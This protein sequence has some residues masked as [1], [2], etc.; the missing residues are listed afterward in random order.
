[1]EERHCKRAILTGRC[2]ISLGVTVV[3]AVALCFVVFIAILFIY[4]VVRKTNKNERASTAGETASA[5]AYA[6]TPQFNQYDLVP[7]YDHIHLLRVRLIS[8]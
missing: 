8:K 1:M 7:P 2:R 6:V 3:I 4:F 5:S